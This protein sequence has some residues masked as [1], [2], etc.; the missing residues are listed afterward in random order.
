LLA[1][2]FEEEEE[3]LRTL[4]EVR[5][6]IRETQDCIS[7]SQKKYRTGITPSDFSS[8]PEE[9]F[10]PVDNIAADIQVTLPSRLRRVQKMFQPHPPSSQVFR[11]RNPMDYR[12]G[13]TRTRH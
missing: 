13:S 8:D 1:S 2:Y 7:D 4:D 3:L 6:R 12:T 10:I 9:N 5:A 11:P